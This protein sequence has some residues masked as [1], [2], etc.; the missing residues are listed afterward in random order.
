[1]TDRDLMLGRCP[2]C[3]ARLTWDA[4]LVEYQGADGTH[5]VVAECDS[6]GQVVTPT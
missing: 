2:A 6:C 5:A 3:S 1:M 4:L